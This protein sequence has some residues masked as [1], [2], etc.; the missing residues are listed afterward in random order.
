[1]PP[2]SFSTLRSRDHAGPPEA[3]HATHGGAAWRRQRHGD[4]S[5]RALDTADVGIDLGT[6]VVPAIGSESRSR[7]TG[8]IPSVTIE[9]KQ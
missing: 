1:L 5:G 6:P 3:P 9:T 7:F 2:A 8:R 4:R